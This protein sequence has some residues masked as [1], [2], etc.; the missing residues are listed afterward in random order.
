VKKSGNFVDKRRECLDTIAPVMPHGIPMQFQEFEQRLVTSRHQQAGQTRRRA[1]EIVTRI[2]MQ[3]TGA[4]RGNQ[5]IGPS[6]G[7]FHRTTDLTPP[8]TDRTKVVNA[9]ILHGLPEPI[10]PF[11][12]RILV[13]RCLDNDG[14]QRIQCLV[15]SRSQSATG[16]VHVL[17]SRPNFLHQTD[18]TLRSNNGIGLRNPF[19]LGDG[20]SKTPA[21]QSRR[22]PAVGAGSEARRE[23]PFV[24]LVLSHGLSGFFEPQWRTQIA[25]R[26]Y[27]FA[28]VVITVVL[29][30]RVPMDSNLRCLPIF[31]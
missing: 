15:H 31:K 9:I 1:V 26:C 28:S 7:N 19:N 5:V 3:P 22:L 24:F 2:R 17:Q 16:T 20:F 21:R 23:N 12:T 8:V 25:F 30:W 13:S 14:N 29:L 11:V 27:P 6:P 18:R 4:Q 10:E